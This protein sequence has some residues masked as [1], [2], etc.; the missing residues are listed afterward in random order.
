MRWQQQVSPKPSQD[1]AVLLLE[2][3]ESLWKELLSCR[4]LPLLWANLGKVSQCSLRDGGKA[5][6]AKG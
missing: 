4:L 5:A 3:A 2:A 6:P 1:R